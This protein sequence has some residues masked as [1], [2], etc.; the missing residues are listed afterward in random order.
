M[1]QPHACQLT[2]P[3]AITWLA[4]CVKE[5]SDYASSVDKA[6]KAPYECA[7]A[8]AG[9]SRCLMAG[10]APRI[11]GDTINGQSIRLQFN[12]GP[13]VTCP[14]PPRPA[15]STRAEAVWTAALKYLL[16]DLK[17]LVMFMAKHRGQ[18]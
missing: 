9:P 16:A 11:K 8:L 17:Q 15:H 7:R 18:A 1:C 5:F 6:F 2:S 4:Q 3:Q 12:N 14:A 10:P 13:P